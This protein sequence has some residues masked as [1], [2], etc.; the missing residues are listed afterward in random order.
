MIAKIAFTVPFKATTQTV[1]HAF[2]PNSI[3]SK[4]SQPQNITQKEIAA[5]KKSDRQKYVLG[6]LAVLGAA[7]VTAAV[8]KF[9]IKPAYVKKDIERVRAKR[10]DF[11]A[12]ILKDEIIPW[13]KKVFEEYG[14]SP[15][16]VDKL[17]RNDCWNLSNPKKKSHLWSNLNSKELRDALT[18]PEIVEETNLTAEKH[19]DLYYRQKKILEKVDDLKDIF[20]RSPE[21]KLI[22]EKLGIPI[23]PF[24]EFRKA[25]DKALDDPAK[26]ELIKPTVIAN[27]KIGHITESIVEKLDLVMKKVG[28]F[29]Y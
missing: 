21:N 14:V 1:A 28:Y 2:N 20:L 4:N 7:V 5:E 26:L 16:L 3:Y 6:T 11:E 22:A 25:F 29:P 9:G 24:E 17:P 18:T 13:A 10:A 8:Y 23:T 19:F 27:I 15:D 12:R